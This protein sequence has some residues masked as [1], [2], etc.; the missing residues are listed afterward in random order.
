M[1]ATSAPVAR[2]ATVTVTTTLD[3]NDGSCNDG[4]CSL[5]DAVATAVSNDIINIPSGSYVLTL[6][7]I[8]VSK[9][10]TLV[11]GSGVSRLDGNATSR[12]FQITGNVNVTLRN[13]LITNGKAADGGGMAV[14]GGNI[15]LVNS[16]IE[17]NAASNNGGGIY[18]ST[19][20]TV[21]LTS[22]GIRQ[23]TA[24]I[25]GGGIYNM[26]GSLVQLGGVIENNSAAT[27][28]GV[29]VNLPGAEFTLNA[30]VVQQNNGTA[31]ETGGGG[32][33]VAQGTVNVN[34]GQISANIGKRG[35]GIQSANGK[36]YL[37]GGIIKQNQAEF[38]GGVY[39]AFPEALLTQNGGEITQNSATAT[40]FGGGG[41]Y[42]FQGS[43]VLNGGVIQQ[44]TAV[45]DGGGINI[46]FGTLTISGG[47]VINNQ[48]GAKGG[49]IFGEQS[50]MAI[51][52]LQLGNNAAV[53]GGGLYL[54]SLASL[55][56]A[57]TAVFS[58]TASLNGGGLL[59]R[60]NALVTNA[61]LGRNQAQNSG[62]GIWSELGTVTLNNAT[63][64]QNTAVT[65]GGLF[66]NS[67]V[68]NLHNSLL[69]G[70]VATNPDCSGTVTSNGYNLVQD[71][72]G[73][74]LTGNLSGNLTGVNPQLASLTLY[75]GSTYIYP[76]EA[77]S[78][79]I[80]AGDP[81]DC[82][83][84]DQHGRPRP[85]DGKLDGIVTC[86]IGAFEYGIPMRI[87]DV[88]VTEG[89]SGSLLANFSVTL[90]FAAPVT[91]TVAY[92]SSNQTAV[93]GLDYT[94]VAGTLTFSPGDLT[95]T[96]AVP[97]VGDLLDEEDETFLITLD[98]PT[99][100][101]LADGQALGTIV[102]NDAAPS[103]SIN[104]IT[105]VEGDSGSK[106]ANFTVTASAPSGKTMQ[107]NY[108]TANGSAVAGGDYTAVSGT[109]IFTPGQTSKTI[110]VNV[111]GDLLDEENETFMVNLSN[112]Q[113]STLSK[114]QGIGTIQDNDPLPKLSINNLSVVEGDG[115]PK[116][117][118]FTISL[119]A[120][121]SK[122]IT[123]NYATA[124]QTAVAGRDYTAKS[125]TLTFTPGQISKTV[126]IT[127]LSDLLA[128]Q[129]ETFAVKLSQP[130]NATLGVTQG[131]G[132]IIDNDPQPPTTAQYLIYLPLVTKP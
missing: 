91:V 114:A 92:A 37:N 113:N 58:N 65:G 129:T 56:L 50:V 27:G 77:T 86:D 54:S 85:L 101:Y 115:P 48:A 47:Q 106:N 36:I 130:V 96:I 80:D 100:A 118:Q 90:D 10:V 123:V 109:L 121:S 103:L 76:L 88:T 13:L 1:F 132:T 83:A 124:D 60:G 16:V 46:R 11:G 17:G 63:V 7:E 45:A 75:S 53:E 51:T 66:N 19:P 78:P 110:T 84:T 64:S 6:G 52:N 99:N 71:T 3:E 116:T 111:L 33:Y 93:A 107:V 105:V 30:G 87:N 82:P 34:G 40:D 89:N 22:G 70:N 117:M 35:G 81:L 49:G 128:E 120:A 125:G 20:G 112:P 28:G 57:Q 42:G 8:V 21:T 67:A 29:Y 59:L 102:D 9:S 74:T 41:V 18:M 126:T 25:G 61:T 119:S 43:M 108:A 31:L 44:N 98:S 12:V 97:I 15:N 73:C 38:G 62:G 104:D 55:N 94:A 122:I 26:S 32:V 69:A 39:L 23:N 79:A 127:I 14:F 95:K 2:A 5:R 131:I 68:V 24:V 72:A 4:D